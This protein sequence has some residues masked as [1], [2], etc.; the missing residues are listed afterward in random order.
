MGST[1]RKVLGLIPVSIVI[2]LAERFPALAVPAPI[3]NYTCLDP[4]ENKETCYEACSGEDWPYFYCGYGG[5][6]KC[7]RHADG[8]GQCRL[9]EKITC[10]P[11][12]ATT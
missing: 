1:R 4:D 10:P 5:R 12:S 9:A 3:A 11:T 2:S 7:C 6:G 8:F